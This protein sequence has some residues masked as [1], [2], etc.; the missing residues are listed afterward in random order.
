MITRYGMSERFGLM[1]LAKVQDMY[2]S[3][4]SVLECGDA[5]ATQVDEEIMKMLAVSYE[6]SKRILSEHLDALH[7]I[8]A[9]LIEKETITGSEFMDILHKV[10][11]TGQYAPSETADKADTGDDGK[12]AETAAL[13]D[14]A[15]EESAETSQSETEPAEEIQTAEENPA[16]SVTP[17]KSD[18]E[19]KAEEARRNDYEQAMAE[20]NIRIPSDKDDVE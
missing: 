10:E 16:V 12:T 17:Q 6:E 9:Y 19:R 11:G 4:R 18:A 5:T 1:G 3:G 13:P 8:A 7:K 2:L 20:A 14:A 15:E